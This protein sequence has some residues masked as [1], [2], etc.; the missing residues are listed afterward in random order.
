MSEAQ[1]ILLQRL[2]G[3]VSPVD[4][5]VAGNSGKKTPHSAHTLARI[6]TICLTCRATGRIRPSADPAFHYQK[7]YK[8]FVVAVVVGRQRWKGDASI[9]HPTLSI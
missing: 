5:I 1:C 2:M 6:N 3:E 7:K 8:R 9:H 4:P